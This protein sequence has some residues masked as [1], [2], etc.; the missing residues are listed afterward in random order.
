MSTASRVLRRVICSAV[1]RLRTLK[2][3]FI[4]ARQHVCRARYAIA[5]LSVRPC[6]T[7]V[8]VNK[9]PSCR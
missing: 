6:H 9:K 1:T 3:C 2:C 5:R 8:S 7:G 4:S